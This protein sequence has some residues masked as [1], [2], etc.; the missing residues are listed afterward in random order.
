[1]T[2]IPP[3]MR[4]RAAASRKLNPATLRQIHADP[5]LISAATFIPIKSIRRIPLS[6]NA[7][8]QNRD[9][10]PGGKNDAHASEPCQYAGKNRGADR[11]EKSEQD[12]SRI[13]RGESSLRSRG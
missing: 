11:I 7:D 3:T 13:P 2:K 12:T 5:R 8:T 10:R 9:S 6:T 4:N 1:M